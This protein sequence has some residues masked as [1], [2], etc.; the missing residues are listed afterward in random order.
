M[1]I[2]NKLLNIRQS[3]DLTMD[4]LVDIFNKE[5]SLSVT[6]GMIS[7]WEND[8]STP[9]MT[10]LR[11][12]AKTFHIDLNQLL[13]IDDIQENEEITQGYYANP[14]TAKMAQEL[15]DNPEM[16]ILFD[17]ARRVS[18]EDLKLAAEIVSRMKQKE[19]FED[20]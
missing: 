3:S 20:K 10:Y 13:S 4:E 12:Y 11:A 16:R 9:S 17:A 15:Y 8:K 5:Y 14:E 6:R 7:R 1:K 19:E 18:A 2:G